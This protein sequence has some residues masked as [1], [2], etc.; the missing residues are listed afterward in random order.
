[1]DILARWGIYN[2]LFDNGLGQKFMVAADLL[3]V[4][5]L[6]AD[7]NTGQLAYTDLHD[8]V[9][10]VSEAP[11]EN[12]IISGSPERQLSVSIERPVLAIT[13]PAP[14]ALGVADAGTFLA[15]W[16]IFS[17][18]LT[19]DMGQQFL[20]AAGQMAGNC[21]GVDEDSQRLIY[22]EAGFGKWLFVNDADEFPG[23][24]AAA[25]PANSGDNLQLEQEITL[26]LSNIS[27]ESRAGPRELFPE[28]EEM[29]PPP[30]YDPNWDSEWDFFYE[31][32]ETPEQRKMV[33][34]RFH[35]P[36]TRESPAKYFMLDESGVSERGVVAGLQPEDMSGVEMQPL[37]GL[38]LPNIVHA[39]DIGISP[40]LEE[41]WMI[42]GKMRKRWKSAWT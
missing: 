24:F 10:W 7:Q 18:V 13:G 38:S 3:D 17:P 31:V 16:G 22:F 9:W 42:S 14:D 8:Q 6:D 28:I 37:P 33:L 25:Q 4:D 39:G 23:I 40:Y 34:Q 35:T 30:V 19:D 32:A 11:A 21:F 15:E 29:P 27:L 36:M 20:M 5:R 2:P 1:M 41:G 26:P 12:N